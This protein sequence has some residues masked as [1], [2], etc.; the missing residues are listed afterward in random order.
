MP[1][2]QTCWCLLKVTDLN[3]AKRAL[4]VREHPEA[5]G[6]WIEKYIGFWHC[7][8]AS[9]SEGKEFERIGKWAEENEIE[10]V[11]WTN[12]PCKFGG[13]NGTMPSAKD[14]L[15]YLR[16]LNGDARTK[17]EAYVRQAPAQIDTEYRRLFV[18]EL[19]WTPLAK[20]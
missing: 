17:A 4:G 11:V 14:A 16:N 5:T 10:G 8:G 1:N 20:A 13:V 7:S 6:R 2:V 18:K 3:E 12:L 15:T 9:A 19:N